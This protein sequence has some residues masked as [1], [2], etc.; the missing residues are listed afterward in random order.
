MDEEL[1]QIEAE[2]IINVDGEEISPVVI[3]VEGEEKDI[4]IQSEVV[5]V[6]VEP[7]E[8]IDI[9]VDEATGWTS[10]DI[11]DHYFLSNRDRKDAHPIASITGLRKELDDLEKL[12]TVYSDKTQQADYYIWH[13]KNPSRENRNGLFISMGEDGIAICRG[14]TDVFGVT[15]SEAGFVGNQQW[16][17]AT[18]AIKVGRDGQYGLVVCSGVAAVRC[19]SNVAVGDYVV[20]NV[21]GEAKKSDGNYGYLVTALSEI[22]GVQYAVISLTTPST[23]TKEIADGVENL[24]GRMDTAEYNI[25]SVVNVA[26]SAYRLA[27]D[28]KENAEV[29]SEYL[30]GKIAEALGRMD[31]IDTLMENLGASV[32]SACESAALAKAIAEGAVSS[33]QLLGNEVVNKANEALAETTSVKKDII[34]SRN[35]LDQLADAMEPLSSWVS[36]D[37]TKMGVSG[38]IAKTDE[39]GTE[40]AMLSKWKS[41]NES[42]VASIAG[43][44]T[45]A[46]NNESKIEE[47]A[48]WKLG[49][50]ESI[51][52]TIT[53]ANEHEATIRSLTSF[54]NEAK[55]TMTTL[56]QKSDANGAKIDALASNIDKHSLG[57]YSQAYNLTW[58]Q[59]KDIL[60]TSIVYVPTIFHSET[61]DAETPYTQEFLKGYY[62]TWSG[63][64]WI[65]SQSNAVFFSNVLVQ[66]AASTPYW[67]VANKD[68]DSSDEETQSE[69]TIQYGYEFGCLYLWQDDIWVKVASASENLLSRAISSLKITSNSISSEVSNVKG[70]FAGT[71]TWVDNN[72]A[73]IQDVVAW[74]GTNGDSLTT[75]MQEAGDNFASISSVAQ[76]VDKDGNVTASSIVQAVNDGKSSIDLNANN[77]NFEADNYTIQANKID[78]T[79][80]DYS[81]DAERIIIKGVTEYHLQQKMEEVENEIHSIQVGG[82]NLFRDSHKDVSNS[83]YQLCT[84]YYGNEIPIGGEEYIISIKGTIDESVHTGFYLNIHDGSDYP[85]MVIVGPEDLCSDG[86]YRKTFIM[87]TL[88]AYLWSILY[89]YPLGMYKEASVDWIQ[90]ERGNVSTDWTAAPEDIE[91]ESEEFSAQITKNLESLQNQIDGNIMT[92]FY[93]YEPTINNQPAINWITDAIKAQHLGDLFYI[94]NNT[95]KNGQV[96][97]WTQVSGVYQWIVVTDAELAKA[98]ANAQKAQ[99]TADNK[100]RVFVAQPTP[101]YDKGDMWSQGATGELMVCVTQR[102]SGSYN[103]SDWEKASKYTDDTAVKNLQ[104]GTRNLLLNSSFKKDRNKWTVNSGSFFSFP[105]GGKYNK[106]CIKITQTEFN[107]TAAIWQSVLEVVEPNT[108]YTMS[109]WIL[110][111]NITAGVAT[112]APFCCMFYCD[113]NYKNNGGNSWYGYGSKSL[114]INNS[115]GEWQHVSWTFTT[116]SKIGTTANTFL[117]YVYTRNMTGEVYIADLK[118]EKGD[119]ATDWTPANEDLDE[120]IANISIGGRNLLKNSRHVQ[121]HSNNS[122]VYPV[123]SEVKEDPDGREFTRYTRSMVE[124][125][126]NIM[127]LYNSIYPSSITE[128]LYGQEVTFSFLARSSCQTDM[129][130]YASVVIDGNSNSVTLYKIPLYTKWTRYAITTTITQ[131]YINNSTALFRNLP[132]KVRIPQGTISNF[133]LDICE[134]K[135]EKGN[136]AT[137]WTASPWDLTLDNTLV[138]YLEKVKANKETIID[139]D[140]IATNSIVAEKINTNGLAAE[141]LE[142]KDEN[143]D[144]IFKADTGKHIVEISAETVNFKG[145]VNFLSNVRDEINVAAV[146]NPNLIPANSA[147]TSVTNGNYPTWGGT[148]TEWLIPGETYTISFCI[149]PSETTKYI[150]PYVSQG[151]KCLAWIY[152]DGTTNKQIVSATFTA[153]YYDGRYPEDNELYGRVQLYHFN[154]NNKNDGSVITIHWVRLERGDKATGTSTIIDGGTIQTGTITAD[155]LKADALQSKNYVADST[156]SFLNLTDG[157]FDSAYFKISN[158]GKITATSGEIGGFSIDNNALTNTLGNSYISIE[159]DNYITYFGANEIRCTKDYTRITEDGKTK[160]EYT[161]ILF[162]PESIGIRSLNNSL[163]SGLSLQPYYQIVDYSKPYRVNSTTTSINGQ[164]ISDLRVNADTFASQVNYTSGSY[165]FWYYNYGWCFGSASGTQVSLST[166][167]ISVSSSSATIGY[168][169]VN[170]TSSTY[171]DNNKTIN[172]GF[173]GPINNNGGL[174]IGSYKERSPYQSVYTNVV[175]R[176]AY[177]QFDNYQ[178]ATLC[179]DSK[180]NGSWTLKDVYTGGSYNIVNAIKNAIV[181]VDSNSYSTSNYHYL[182]FGNNMIIQWGY[183]LPLMSSGHF[184]IT[185]PKVMNGTNY[186]ILATRRDVNDTDMP[187]CALVKYNSV[188]TTGFTIYNNG[189][190]EYKCGLYWM[191]I[192]KC[193]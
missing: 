10:G 32:G 72:K 162:T 5:V 188:A 168:F 144:V 2:T 93:D 63:A 119:K 98:L 68:E 92:W 42:E 163:Y 135:I 129:D 18:G 38:F 176:G 1:I 21:R 166:Y 49:N 13:D 175:E 4:E 22:N 78:F 142:V 132:N 110:T 25:T 40:I 43:I 17:E 3:P 146:G 151:A 48:S 55:S 75:F 153:G 7:E 140:I 155:Q 130:Y 81:I 9:E 109:G 44:R 170:L 101:P 138:G 116:D 141:Y 74:K 88:S 97:R 58:Q 167:G 104:I 66:G 6:N 26:D 126:P 90:L 12:Q 46:D 95:E 61:Y 31:D 172:N 45:K 137:D 60:P 64:Q 181:D 169:T 134:W 29:N 191:V 34:L 118:L 158:D 111:E 86:V 83:E 115:T 15:V 80:K 77:I 37:G 185:L 190:Y 187:E 28:A 54:E 164:N 76:V 125:Q 82:R 183:N 154:A 159:K 139:G 96:Y 145:S 133:Y 131:N 65:P 100:R 117:M 103:S 148:P 157:S 99:D 94:V 102:L 57:E 165:S 161:G 67:V 53:K 27:Q 62:Y 84:Y 180:I 112:D 114:P 69:D 152:T 79:G 147:Y 35:E 156:G 113:G 91:Q 39:N 85:T 178:N 56:T 177:L 89:T 121:L 174:I 105:E 189:S 23:I 52:S 36:E 30:E 186:T 106:K 87:P 193:A 59:A 179:Y 120:K 51:A 127:S 71:K 20:S 184:V 41:D 8:E 192:G 128:D 124:S 19:E 33:A 123:I 108:T 107:K 171:Y 149:T 136:K 143:E 73:A 182:K 50:E 24:S 70:D 160:Y 11:N 47:I 122:S 150:C 14:E 16:A 173:V